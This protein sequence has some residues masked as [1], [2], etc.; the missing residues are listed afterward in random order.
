MLEARG[1]TNFSTWY[2]HESIRTFVRKD[3]PTHIK[4]SKNARELA[5][6]IVTENEL[7]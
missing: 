7:L 6:C 3:K 5:Q 1:A 2:I 4:T